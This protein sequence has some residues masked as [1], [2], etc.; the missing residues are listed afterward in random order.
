MDWF[1]SQG[2]AA[3]QP[4]NFERYLFNNTQVMFLFF[5]LS[6]LFGAG[7]IFILAWNASVIAVFVGILANKLVPALGAPMAYVYGVG[8]GLG[9]IALHGVPEIAGY[10][11]AGVAGGILS[12]GLLREKFM[13]KE[14]KEMAKD[15]LIWIGIGE[16]LIILGAFLE[17]FF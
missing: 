6:V 7:A 15:S 13:S 16:G 14:F 10:F 3:V 4:G 1:R 5:I 17:A 8:A 2:I 12:V 9:S 11:F